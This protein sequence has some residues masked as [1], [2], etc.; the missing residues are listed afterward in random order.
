LI[1]QEK[2]ITK[3]F[4]DPRPRAGEGTGEGKSQAATLLDKIAVPVDASLSLP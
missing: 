1:S 4:C 2:R 3:V